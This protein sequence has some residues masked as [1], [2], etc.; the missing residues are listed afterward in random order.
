MRLEK[1]NLAIILLAAFI[2][3]LGGLQVAAAKKKGNGGGG[4]ACKIIISAKAIPLKV[5]Q[6]HDGNALIK[7][8][9][10]NR[11]LEVWEKEDIEGWDFWIL[12]VFN[13]GSTANEITVSFYDVEVTPKHLINTFDLMM[14]KKGEKIIPHRVKLSKK[15]FKAN[16]RYMIQV[17][18]KQVTKGEQEFNLRGKEIKYSGEVNFSDDEAKGKLE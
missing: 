3:T 12:L 6:K 11:S 4:K 17:S 18:I 7:W 8:F 13:K 16:H 2:L 14:M 9:S 1:R 10:A 5:F 15:E